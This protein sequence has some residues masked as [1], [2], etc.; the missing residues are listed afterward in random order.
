M[1]TLT[2]SHK[3]PSE[4]KAD[5]VVILALPQTSQPNDEPTLHLRAPALDGAA[6]QSVV[7]AAHHLLSRANW[8][9]PRGNVPPCEPLVFTG[10]AGIAPPVTVVAVAASDEPEAIRRAAGQAVRA[11]T[12]PVTVAVVGT[13]DVTTSLAAVEGVALG[14]YRFTHHRSKPT[15]QLEQVILCSEP[16]TA[17]LQQQLERSQ[18]IV[19]AVCAARDLVNTSPAHLSPGAFAEKAVDSASDT[20]VT[21]E[22]L[23]ETELA[24]DGYGGIMAVGQGST[25]PPRLV[26]LTY[27]PAEAY[28][29]LALVG[30]GITFDSGGLSLKTGAGMMTMKSDM[31]G[32]AAVLEATLAIARLGIRT[33]VTSYLALAE[34]M[35]SATA[36]RPGDVITMF[37]GTTV[38]VL[39]TDAEGRLVMADALA[40]TADD[41]PDLIIDVATLT[42]AQIVAL[43]Y[44]VAAAMALDADARQQVVDAA[45]RAGEMLWPMP[46]PPGLRASL[47]SKIADMANIGDRMGGMLTAG[48]FLAEFAPS[49]TPWVHLDIAG[50]SFNDG[51]SRDYCPP[52]GTGS[53]VRTLVQVAAELADH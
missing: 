22:V 1:T 52:G 2:L 7:A 8:P 20:E 36:Q 43:G 33:A 51:P 49:E 13:G 14:G 10:I 26:R 47:D 12:D 48:L 3:S 15:P 35:P 19:D 24:R 34:N 18:V 4:I 39:N 6:G 17:E 31:A 21:V 50:P 38:E 11:I 25:R 28:Q 44:E 32:A 45:E 41:E 16:D 29:H 53:M 5:A 42:G 27:R 9:H 46:L 37:N 40:R 30:K 23:D